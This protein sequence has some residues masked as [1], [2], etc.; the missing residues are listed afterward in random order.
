[1]GRYDSVKK[2]MDTRQNIK[3]YSTTLYDEIPKL[4]SDIYVIA[5]EGDRL[6]SLAF[7]YYG[8]Q[9][10]WWFIARANNIKT[11]NVSAGTRLRIPSSTEKAKGN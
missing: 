3:K 8:D 4:N 1:M 5:Q 6:D 7:E 11:M 9:H 10:L 2:S